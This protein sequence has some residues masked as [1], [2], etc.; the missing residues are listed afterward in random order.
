MSYAVDIHKA[1]QQGMALVRADADWS[2]LHGNAHWR[3]LAN[4]TEPSVC[5]GDAA[6]C[7]ITL[8]IVVYDWHFFTVVNKWRNWQISET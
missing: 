7:Q 6:L 3:N 5:N 1:T 4:T 8:T 2:V